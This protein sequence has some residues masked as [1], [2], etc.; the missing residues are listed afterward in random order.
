MNTN[1]IIAIIAVINILMSLC[2]IRLNNKVFLFSKAVITLTLITPQGKVLVNLQ[3]AVQK[4]DKEE[5]K[6][7]IEEL[8]K[9]DDHIRVNM[10]KVDSLFRRNNR[11]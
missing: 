7:M 3:E 4:G 1:I 8:T 9:L 2:I 5:T 10:D 6:R 11:G